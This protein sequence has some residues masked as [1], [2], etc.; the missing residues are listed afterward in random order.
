MDD[1]MVERV[2]RFN[3]AVAQRVG[4]LDDR[5]LARDRP[6]AEA[7]VLWEIG[8]EGREVRSLRSRL[9][10]DSGHASR[11][12]RALERDGLIRMVPSSADGRVRRAELTAA[13][14][15][16]REQ[17]DRSSDD[18]AKSFLTP[19]SP[20]QRD[21]LV[22]AMGDV[23]RLLTA[24]LVE[25]RPVHPRHPDA[26]A[27]FRRYFAELDRRSELG[28]D[29]A[30]GISA[31]PH[32]LV[33]PA[34]A[35]LVAYLREEPVGCGAVKHHDAAPSEIKRMWVA[36]TARGLGLGRRLLGEL[37]ACA[38]RA[39][40]PAARLETNRVLTEGISLYRSAGYAEVAA[41]N[42]EPFADHWFEKP[43]R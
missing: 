27:C 8:R 23:E 11:L 19:L 4:A 24:A 35:L 31:E 16:E 10:L 18:L 37:E 14:V 30:Q 39:G 36:E 15:A 7:R 40:A 20:G 5:F 6:M 13:G 17:L 33:P 26:Q 41:F 1:V 42:D 34:G 3:R 38:A 9:G 43:L 22:A 32:E 28:F 2:R 29:P 21:R 12:L 25:I